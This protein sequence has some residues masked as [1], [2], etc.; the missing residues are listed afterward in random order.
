MMKKILITGGNGQLGREINELMPDFTE[1]DFL[2]TDV[3]DLDIADPDMLDQFFETHQ[4]DFVINCAAYTAVDKAEEDTGA[5]YTVNV[6]GPENLAVACKNHRSKLIHIS[7]DYV[8]DGR[9]YKPYIETDT[10]CPTG[11]YGQ[12]KLEGEQK[13]FSANDE[14]II[15]RT[16]WLYSAFGS[17][18]VKTML[19][20]G[21]ERDN[22]SVV[23]DQIGTP[24]YARDLAK[25]ILQIIVQTEK[26][27]SR[28]QPGIYHFSNEGVC[29][30]YDFAVE[31][32]SQAGIPCRISPIESKDFPTKAERPH[33]SVL[34]KAKIKSAFEIE[35]PY[36]KESLRNCIIAL[37]N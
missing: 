9:N 25:V 29:S 12:T 28:W 4:P 24:T 20:L 27:R 33:F 35:I 15:I 37:T 3:E 10:P 26:H 2:F 18:F 17:N 31:I 6:N 34:N 13:S 7:T 1:F 14:S 22:L 19:R 8:F 32:M 11:V 16:S 36:W 5:A 30:W 23:F 21:K